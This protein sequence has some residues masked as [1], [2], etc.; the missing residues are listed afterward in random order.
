MKKNMTQAKGIAATIG[1]T[2]LFTML[3]TGGAIAADTATGTNCRVPT[4]A[5]DRCSV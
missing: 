2:A 3:L 5:D 1:A 4:A